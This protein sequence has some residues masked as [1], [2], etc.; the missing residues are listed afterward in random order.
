MFVHFP[1]DLTASEADSNLA[2]VGR[3]YSRLA[4]GPWALYLYKEVGWDTESKLDDDGTPLAL[5]GSPVI[6][7]PGNAGSFRQVRSLA[8]AASRTY[9]E[10]PRVKRKGIGGKGSASLDF[11]TLDFNDDFSAF[12]GQTLLDQAEYLADAITFILSLYQRHQPQDKP[13][14]SSLCRAP[15][16]TTDWD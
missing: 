6:F 16:G 2:C 11:F 4:G 3:E 9:W 12:H 14:E 10:L 13:G 7:V 8:G 15:R 1:L 5:N